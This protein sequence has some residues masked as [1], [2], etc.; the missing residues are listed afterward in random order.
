MSIVLLILFIGCLICGF[1]SFVVGN[2][3][4]T[5]IYLIMALLMYFLYNTAAQE[6][7]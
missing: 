7:E 1:F 4:N 2:F 3:T 6:K 5:A